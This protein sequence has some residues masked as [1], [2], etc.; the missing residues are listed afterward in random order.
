MHYSG[1][2]HDPGQWE[3]TVLYNSSSWG[4]SGT[5]R[6]CTQVEVERGL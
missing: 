5:W 2:P 4:S 1:K 6:V 3:M